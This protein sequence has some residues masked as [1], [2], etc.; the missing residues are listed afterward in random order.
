MET[1]VA[2]AIVVIFSLAT[3]LKD[4]IDSSET[5]KNNLGSVFQSGWLYILFLIQ[6]VAA[7][8]VF[9][10]LGKSGKFHTNS[11][12]DGAIVGLLFPALLKS[13]FVKSEKG[14]I[15]IY[16]FWINFITL[17]VYSYVSISNTAKR[18]KLTKL[19]AD[20]NE[21]EELERTVYSYIDNTDWTQEQKHMEKQKLE[22]ELKEIDNKY[23]S[24]IE[25][26]V[27]R[28]DNEKKQ[29]LARHILIIT[30]AR[31]KILRKL[32]LIP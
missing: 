9:Y 29:T 18:V 13:K 20:F 4:L 5:L 23:P 25:E 8:G 6:G 28:R 15:E 1:V 12:W 22:T 26:T 7:A 27:Q 16:D 10:A 21:F 14:I 19:I 2:Y 3:T 17:K 11:I 32:E 24:P 30:K 31:E